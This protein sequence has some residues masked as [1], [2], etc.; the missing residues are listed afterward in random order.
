MA[1]EFDV[2]VLT[3]GLLHFL[4]ALEKQGSRWMLLRL[5]KLVLVLILWPK[6]GVVELKLEPKTSLLYLEQEEIESLKIIAEAIVPFTKL[7]LNLV[8]MYYIGGAVH[9]SISYL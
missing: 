2:A 4:Q 9:C 6:L 7:A 8:C 3:I 5:P 1:S